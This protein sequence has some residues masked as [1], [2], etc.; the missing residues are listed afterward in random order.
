MQHRRTASL[1]KRV[2][3]K[4][5][6]H[7]RSAGIR[8]YAGIP[9]GCARA[10][11]VHEGRRE[12]PP[13]SVGAHFHD[14]RSTRAVIAPRCFQKRQKGTIDLAVGICPQICPFAGLTKLVEAMGV[15]NG[16]E[17]SADRDRPITWK[18]P[19]HKAQDDLI[20]RR[21]SQKRA[22]LPE[23]W[24][25][26]AAA[27]RGPRACGHAAGQFSRPESVAATVVRTRRFAE[28]AGR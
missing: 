24:T 7:S 20:I 1:V 21:S 17:R 11:V 3:T 15:A 28:D 23:P 9:R 16:D 19:D 10:R 18:E 27:R 13:T 22:Q 8:P 25:G 6:S 2:N 5:I 26:P 12:A 4:M 14:V